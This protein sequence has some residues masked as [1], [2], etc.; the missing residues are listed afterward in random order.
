MG[1][2]SAE[3]TKF[4]FDNPGNTLVGQIT[5][6]KETQFGCKAYNLIDSKKDRFYFFGSTNLDAK[7]SDCTGKI[8]SI[9][10]RGKKDIAGGK[11]LKLFEVSIW[12]SDTGSL[13]EGFE[14][15]LH[16]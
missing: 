15:E 5:G 13:P 7:L 14:D 2:K 16:F 6:V 11:T 12:E 9:T 3:P 4:V 10:Y 8:V 1:W